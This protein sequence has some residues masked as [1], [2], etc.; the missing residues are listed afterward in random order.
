MYLCQ[1]T[2]AFIA[3]NLYVGQFHFK[4][5]VIS[6]ENYVIIYYLRLEEKSLKDLKAKILNYQKSE[7]KWRIKNENKKV[8]KKYTGRK[9]HISY[10][11][12]FL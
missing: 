4:M 2:S 9:E 10:S 5:K 8:F 11:H 6:N 7:Y 1:I 3:K 12:Y